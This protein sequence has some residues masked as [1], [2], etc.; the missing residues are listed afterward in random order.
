MFS[1]LPELIKSAAGSLVIGVVATI[2]CVALLLFIIGN[3]RP[4]HSFSPVSFAVAALLALLLAWQLVPMCGAIALKGH[5]SEISDWLSTVSHTGNRLADSLQEQF[6]WVSPFIDPA[7]ISQAGDTADAATAVLDSIK[8]SLDTF[9]WKSVA[10]SLL[11]LSVGTFVI[12]KTMDGG[13]MTTRRGTYARNP[14]GYRRAGNA[15]AATS[16]R[17]RRHR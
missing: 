3:C 12:A 2:V 16:A 14:D 11:W 8:A 1:L 17:H 5:C 10:W 9:I 7:T 13:K 15:R 6:P 4:S